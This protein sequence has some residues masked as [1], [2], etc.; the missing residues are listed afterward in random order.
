MTYDF[1]INTENVNEYYYRVL[2]AGIDFE[3]YM[4]NPVVLFMHEREYDKDD[5]N[6]GSAVIGRCVKLWTRGTELI[7]T[8]EFDMA[9]EFAAKIAGKVERGFIRM[10]S[11]FADVKSTSSEPELILPGQIFETVTT[12]KLVEI[13]VVEIG[14]NDDALKLSK[15]HMEQV[16]LKKINS[17]NNSDMSHLKT[18]ALALGLSAE[19]PEETVLKEVQSLR[20]A[21]ETAEQ[22]AAG[23]EVQLK[24][25]QTAEATALV[26]KAV[27]LGLIPEALKDSSLKSFEFDHAGQKAIL[28]KLIEEKE[29]DGSQSETH[30]AVREVVLG[31]KGNQA[32]AVETFDYLQKHDPV[33]LG[34]I[35]SENPAQYAQ[36][37]KDYAAG[38]RHQESK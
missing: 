4:R 25:I 14:G 19:T 24:G 38:V 15:K 12:C 28:S 9:D 16:K 30:Q 26:D 13:S 37:A 21:K 3:Q 18:I 7:A 17:E 29:A 31:K 5:D 6:K 35:R 10:A 36:L 1:I 33:K 27:T 2:T 11:M 32:P 22:K 23:L 34:K 8:I 20:L